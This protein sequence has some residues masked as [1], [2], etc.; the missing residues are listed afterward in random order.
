[1]PLAEEL[2]GENNGPD[3]YTRPDIGLGNLEGTTDGKLHQ[4][5]QGNGQNRID[6]GRNHG[7]PAGFEIGFHRFPLVQRVNG[8]L[9]TVARIRLTLQSLH[10][11]IPLLE[12]GVSGLA[13]I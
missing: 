3:Q 10:A 5:H 11:G 8:V 9:I 12:I 4:E 13:S 6:H 1:M 2:G 7:L